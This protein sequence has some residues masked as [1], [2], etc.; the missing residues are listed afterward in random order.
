I[1]V[2]K[3]AMCNPHLLST[4][5]PIEDDKTFHI[6]TFLDVLRTYNVIFYAERQRRGDTEKTLSTELSSLLAR[7]FD[8]PKINSIS[9]ILFHCT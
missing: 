3:I 2:S 6:I 9:I 7:A 4:L 1:G 5:F 8:I